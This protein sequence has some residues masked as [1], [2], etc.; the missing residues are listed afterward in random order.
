MGS[1]NGRPNWIVA[2]PDRAASMGRRYAPRGPQRIA[3]IPGW[4]DPRMPLPAGEVSEWLK[5][6]DWKSRKRATVSGVR[7]PPSPLFFPSHGSVGC[8][9]IVATPGRW[10]HIAE[11][12]RAGWRA[13]GHAR[14]VCCWDERGR[15]CDGRGRKL[16]AHGT[17]GED[18]DVLPQGLQN[19]SGTRAG[20]F[21]ATRR[22][23]W[24]DPA[25]RQRMRETCHAYA[26]RLLC[27]C[28]AR[29]GDDFYACWQEKCECIKKIEYR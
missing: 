24:L 3:L 5:E 26:E 2:S 16:M 25:Y 11:C 9:A 1:A 6:R 14:R 13:A 28:V 4:N 7:I 23:E 20:H 17:H 21:D 8:R 27:P 22:P 18:T 10:W 19:I 15:W 12:M 29:A